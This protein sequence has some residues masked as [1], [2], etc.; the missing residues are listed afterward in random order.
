MLGSVDELL[1]IGGF[2]RRCGLSAKVLRSYAAV[3][4]L[5]PAAV[6]P[7]TGYLDQ[8]VVATGHQGHGVAV[9]VL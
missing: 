1:G 8:I 9:P 4:L 2:S 7:N 3:G 6:D 5:T